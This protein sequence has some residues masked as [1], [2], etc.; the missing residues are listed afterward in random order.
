MHATLFRLLK[1][2]TKLQKPCI[3]FST[4]HS[5]TQ[6]S[7]TSKE[8]NTQFRF[9]IMTKYKKTSETFKQRLEILQIMTL[10]F[11]LVK[12][13]W[14]EAGQLFNAITGLCAAGRCVAVHNKCG[15]VGNTTPKQYSGLCVRW[16]CKHCRMFSCVLAVYS[17]AF[18]SKN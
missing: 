8:K 2:H 1:N 18:S 17:A 7:V 13:F 16:V 15:L 4:C 5:Y 6:L 10:L 11:K 12:A 9:R 14:M 3:L